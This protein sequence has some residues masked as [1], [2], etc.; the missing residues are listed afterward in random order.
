MSFNW[1]TEKY[2]RIERNDGIIKMTFTIKI[3]NKNNAVSPTDLTKEQA[4]DIVKV[5]LGMPGIHKITITWDQIPSPKSVPIKTTY[6]EQGCAIVDH[7]I[8]SIE[9]TEPDEIEPET[10]K[11]AGQF[12]EISKIPKTR[13]GT[14]TD[15]LSHD[16]GFHDQGN[17][18]VIIIYGMTKVFTKWKDIQAIPYPIKNSLDHLPKLK[19]KAIKHFKEWIVQG[20]PE[21]YVD[22]DDKYRQQLKLDTHTKDGGDFENTSGEYDGK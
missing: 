15:L 4:D 8:A 9:E 20:K 3:S 22:P 5:L 2:R 1:K 19:Q 11:Q 7:P 18:N 16:M 14:Y 13:Y 10:T 6:P 17:G 12:N 21:K